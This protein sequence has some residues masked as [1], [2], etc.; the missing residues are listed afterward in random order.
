MVK[1][2]PATL[3]KSPA[4]A[5]LLGLIGGKIILRPDHAGL[6]AEAPLAQVS[7]ML[8]LKDPKIHW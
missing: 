3:A 6:I 4:R 7:K 2:L 5:E 8:N 1:D